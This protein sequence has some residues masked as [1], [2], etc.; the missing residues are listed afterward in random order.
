[1]ET[2]EIWKR[3]DYNY[4]WYEVSTLGRIRTVAA[5]PR[6]L[7]VKQN[8][9]GAPT[10]RIVYRTCNG[11]K[12][13]SFL[14]LPKLVADTF[15]DL[16]PNPHNLPLL[17]YRDGNEMNCAVDNLHWKAYKYAAQ[18]TITSKNSEKLAR[19]A[20]KHAEAIAGQQQWWDAMTYAEQQD[21]LKLGQP[22]EGVKLKEKDDGANE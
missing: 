16:V 9:K 5:T 1:M 4:A 10:V 3:I 22:M 13:L 7:T 15:P 8:L 12:Q 2:I 20:Q 21:M 17:G 6:Y 11:R 18:Q 14:S 19:K